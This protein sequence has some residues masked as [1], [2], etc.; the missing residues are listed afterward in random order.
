M[1]YPVTYYCPRC[2]AVVELEREGY[3]ADKS[4]TP[5][6]LEGWTYVGADEDVEAA[7]GVRFVCGEDGTL[8]DDDASGCGEPFYLSYVRFEDGEAVEARPE[9]EYVRLGR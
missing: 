9:S 4:V 1:S 3:L 6:P 5:Y 2:E 7:D 8:R